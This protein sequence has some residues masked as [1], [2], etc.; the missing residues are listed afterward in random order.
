MTGL[1][2]CFSNVAPFLLLILALMLV[3]ERTLSAA[4][5]L[6][7]S[8]PEDDRAATSSS[9][10]YE[11]VADPR[12]GF[13]LMNARAETPQLLRFF[14]GKWSAEQVTLNGER[15]VARRLFDCGNGR[16][17]GT[18]EARGRAGRW[19]AQLTADGWKFLCESDGRLGERV[20][21]DEQGRVW[22]FGQL[23]EIRWFEN[24]QW[25]RYVPEYRSSDGQRRGTPLGGMPPEAFPSLHIAEMED[26]AIWFWSEPRNTRGWSAMVLDGMLVHER[27]RWLQLRDLDDNDRSRFGAGAMLGKRF[28]LVSSQDGVATVDV[29]EHTR[30][31]METLDT[32]IGRG[33][34]AT[35]L[36]RDAGGDVWLVAHPMTGGMGFFQRPAPINPLGELWRFDGEELQQVTAN[37][38]AA[39]SD[40]TGYLR[41][42][43]QD[44]RGNI[45][46]GTLGEGV[47]VV[48]DGELRRV[49]WRDGLRLGTVHQIVSS[50]D[51]QILF[52][53]RT[54]GAVV[55]DVK[56]LLDARPQPAA[57]RWRTEMAGEI[58]ADKDGNLWAIRGAGSS[59]ARLMKFDGEEWTQPIR[60]PTDADLNRVTGISV[61]SRGAV[62]LF[63]PE[64]RVL[65]HDGRRW[66]SYESLQ[67]AITPL[68]PLPANYSLNVPRWKGGV[69]AMPDGSAWVAEFP[70]R[71]YY[72][73]R[74]GRWEFFAPSS[75]EGRSRAFTSAPFIG[76]DGGMC[77]RTP[78]GIWL[79]LD[80][81]WYQSAL[82]RTPDEERRA[83]FFRRVP[84]Q[85]QW[86]AQ[87]AAV[88]PPLRGE[89]NVD[90]KAPLLLVGRQGV[91]RFANG[92][93]ETVESDSNPLSGTT[94]IFDVKTDKSGALW[95]RVEMG[96][97]TTRQQDFGDPAMRFL[98]G[99]GI[100]PGQPQFTPGRWVVWKREP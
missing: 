18:F 84:P 15:V 89:I 4:E 92:K 3:S 5:S 41:P 83:Q 70:D 72:G 77:I 78:N 88:F 44:S 38:D 11:A 60:Q 48:A 14:D 80:N 52:C 99:R 10:Y 47:A 43:A 63:F 98:R 57:S 93:W 34:A 79:R 76:D 29:R 7:K 91:Y 9:D 49:N 39:G 25:S 53:H 55:A 32:G 33:F 87:P 8:F 58:A 19:I 56:L 74:E 75:I 51:G 37:L 2:N 64:R 26:G 95:V 27:G 67:A 31:R 46:L 69:L 85:A 61:D 100:G 36:W 35:A 68:L 40:A 20:Y 86:P 23:R 81:Q 96:G 66:Q 22:A 97:A 16:V 30:K 65:V 45:W 28:L 13:W 42:F 50:R 73:D 82:T 24:G 62:W 59:D 54:L 17:V 90:E 12:G 1:G 6:W 21:L 71:L 94:Q